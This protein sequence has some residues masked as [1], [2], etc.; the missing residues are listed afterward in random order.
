[1]EF[2]ERGVVVVEFDE[3]V[4]FVEF[5]EIWEGLVVVVVVGEEGF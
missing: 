1:M 5:V 4:E 2:L 3:L